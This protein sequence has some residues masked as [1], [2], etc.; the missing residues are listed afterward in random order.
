MGRSKADVESKN[1]NAE[2]LVPISKRA[3]RPQIDTTREVEVVNF[4]SGGL[5][6]RSPKSGREWDMCEFGSSDFMSV[7]ELKTMLSAH[8]KFLREPWLL[9]MDTEVVEYL[10]LSKLYEQIHMPEEVDRLFF[11]PIEKLKAVLENA[12]NG[13]KPLLVGRARALI[14]SGQL[15]SNSYIKAIEKIFDITFDLE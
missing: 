7:D 9:V 13:M 5:F 4:T 10:Q 3:V 15:D 1:I 2:A 14:E 12:P 8:P 11:L 6:Y